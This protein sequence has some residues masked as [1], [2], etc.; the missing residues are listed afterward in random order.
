MLS[1]YQAI[2]TNKVVNTRNAKGYEI[3]RW[4]YIDMMKA[5][6]PGTDL[7]E[8]IFSINENKIVTENI[9]RDIVLDL[10]QDEFEYKN[11][12]Y[13]VCMVD[14]YSVWRKKFNKYWNPMT[15]Q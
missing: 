12:M 10:S 5:M 3:K 7:E 13:P 6:D 11:L 2:I 9:G 4:Y 14:D 1:L 8:A 15:Y